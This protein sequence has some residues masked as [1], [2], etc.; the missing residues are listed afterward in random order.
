MGDVGLRVE[1]LLLMYIVGT[2]IFV[3]LFTYRVLLPSQKQEEAYDSNKNLLTV[4]SFLILQ[5]QS[6]LFSACND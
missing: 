6:L 2:N 4:V 3:Q 5:R 1:P